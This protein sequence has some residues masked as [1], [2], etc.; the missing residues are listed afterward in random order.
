MKE[1]NE[2]KIGG[3]KYLCY[4][5]VRKFEKKYGYISKFNGNVRIAPV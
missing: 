2:K 1:D 3:K 4:L 5:G